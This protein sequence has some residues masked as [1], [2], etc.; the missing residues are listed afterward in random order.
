M[1]IELTEKKAAIA[2]AI[3][4]EIARRDLQAQKDAEALHDDEID[5][6]RRATR[7]ENNRSIK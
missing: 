4:E 6:K 2:K 1:E 7:A 5:I 3:K